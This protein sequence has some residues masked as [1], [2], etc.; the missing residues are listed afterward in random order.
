MEW[1]SQAFGVKR[2]WEFGALD[3]ED[4][5]MF[6]FMSHQAHFEE[7]GT[8]NGLFSLEVDEVPQQAADISVFVCVCCPPEIQGLLIGFAYCSL[9]AY[10]QGDVRVVEG[11]LQSGSSQQPMAVLEFFF[12]LLSQT[13]RSIN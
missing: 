10:T 13:N 7:L 8:E 1:E 5:R 12:Q 3:D 11:I 4:A 2:F 6:F 9:A